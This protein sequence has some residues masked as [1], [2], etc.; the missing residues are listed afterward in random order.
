MPLVQKLSSL[1]RSDAEHYVYTRIPSGAATQAEKPL[2]QGED[3]FRLTLCEMYLGTDRQW[4]TTYYPA[5]HS[6][7]RLQYGSRTVDLPHIAGPLN[8]NGVS[9]AN[10]GHV[11]QLN[12]R[13]TGLLPYNGGELELSAGM[14]AIKGDDALPRIIGV[15]SQFGGML[16]IP[17][18]SSALA[19]A[20]PLATGIQSLFVEG[21]EAVVL[22]LHQSFAVSGA[23]GADDAP[24]PGYFAAFLATERDLS[25]MRLGVEQNRLRVSGNGG[26][27]A[28]LSGDSRHALPARPAGRAR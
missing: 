8:L 26:G 1:F 21:D 18:L 12:H 24:V 14:L 23:A 20:G 5:V 28:A 17:Q 9:S 4:F 3:Y 27:A 19:V 22:G 2:R 25:G 16:Q 13:M 6:L 7:V 15:L 10:L 11:I